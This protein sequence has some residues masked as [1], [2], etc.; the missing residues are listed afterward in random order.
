MIDGELR[1][2]LEHAELEALAQAKGVVKAS[3]RDL[4]V[5]MVRKQSAG[6]TVSATMLLAD[7]AGIDIF[8]TG[9][10]AACI[11]VQSR[12]SISLPT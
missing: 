9:G 8:A 5:A 7:L 6:T 11:A 2:G 10:L 3:G 4:A 12:A 1:A